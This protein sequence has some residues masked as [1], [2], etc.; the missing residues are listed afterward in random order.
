MSPFPEVLSDSLYL[1]ILFQVQDIS[2]AAS[3]QYEL[4][5]EDSL[6][7]S[8]QTASRVTATSLGS[9]TVKLTDM[10]ISSDAAG[11]DG[12]QDFRFPSADLTVV[13]PAYITLNI[14]P[15][16]NWNVIVGND[17]QIHVQ[18]RKSTV[19][20]NLTGLKYI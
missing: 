1:P 12:H 11:G 2:L 4:V 18:V 3:T 17:Y 10:H 19:F 6:V 15:H 20:C 5:V 7:A 14:D 16:D 9:T 8:P 13:E